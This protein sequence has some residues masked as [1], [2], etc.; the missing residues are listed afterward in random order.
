MVVGGR[1]VVEDCLD[2]CEVEN[3]EL[4]RQAVTVVFRGG[5]IVEEV[6]NVQRDGDV[7][8][9]EAIQS[10]AV[11]QTAW[12]LHEVL[13]AR[14]GVPKVRDQGREPGGPFFLKRIILAVARSVADVIAV[15]IGFIYL[16]GA[17]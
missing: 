16:K 17:A 13:A 14:Q 11:R 10:K 2:E 3:L 8:F 15:W 1:L 12:E 9:F 7:Q 4:E 6:F 5:E